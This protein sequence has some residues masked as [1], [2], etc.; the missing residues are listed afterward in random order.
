M[1]MKSKSRLIPHFLA[2]KLL[3]II[4]V[5]MGTDVITTDTSKTGISDYI[6]IRVETLKTSANLKLRYM[7]IKLNAPES[8]QIILGLEHFQ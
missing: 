6:A 5:E 2:R 7:D 8:I 1:L 4:I 3:P